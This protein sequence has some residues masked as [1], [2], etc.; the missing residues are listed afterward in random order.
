MMGWTEV[1]LVSEELQQLLGGEP[2][3]GV[4]ELGDVTRLVQ[5]TFHFLHGVETDSGVTLT[6][7]RTRRAAWRRRRAR[8]GLSFS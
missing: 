8:R 7:V 6:P 2:P 5:A 4:D 3:E 1:A